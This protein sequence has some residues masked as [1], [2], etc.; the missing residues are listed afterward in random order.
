MVILEIKLFKF[1]V[2][3]IKRSSKFIQFKINIHE[4]YCKYYSINLSIC[5][6]CSNASIRK[7]GLNII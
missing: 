3:M 2:Y 1:H 4:T 5:I 7:M 6:G